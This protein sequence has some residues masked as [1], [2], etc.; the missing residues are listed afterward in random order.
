MRDIPKAYNPSD[1]EG[2]WYKYWEER[3]YFKPRE[4]GEPFSIVIP[5]PN[6]TGLL[7]IGHALNNTLQDIIVRYK[8]MQGYSVLWI[9]GTDH[10]GIATQNV[11]ERELLKEGIRKE[12]L[13]REKF[14]EKVWEWKEKLGGRIIEQL[15]R[16]GASCDWSKLRF[17]M[18]EGLSYAVREVFFRL[19]K[20]NLI[21][22]GDYIINWCPKCYTALSDLEVDYKEEAGKLYYVKYPIEGEDDYIIIATTRPETMLGDT[23][24]CVNPKDERYKKYIGKT[25]ILPLVGRRLPII[26]DEV[27]SMDFGTGA[28]KVTPSH[29]PVDFELGKKHNLDFI[30]IMD[31]YAVMNDNAA[32]YRGLTREE[33]REKIVKDLEEKGYLIKVEDYVHSVGHCY[34]CGT[35]IEPMVSTQWFVRTKPLSKP[36]IIA[37]RDKKTRFIPSQWEK[38]YF[39]WMENIKDWCISR[40]IWWGH[41]IPVWYKD[42]VLDVSKR[43][44]DVVDDLGI[45]ELIGRDDVI[46]EFEMLDVSDG[47]MIR[48]GREDMDR[49]L[50]EG[51]YRVYLVSSSYELMK[52]YEEIGFLQESDTLDTWFSSG[53]WP[54]S[55]MGWPHKTPLLEKYYPT[56]LLVTGFDIIFFWV[57]RMMMLG[58]RFMNDVPFRDVYIHALILDEKGQKMSK[59]RGNVIDPIVMMDKYGTDALRFTLAILT[60]QGRNI[61][62]SESHIEGYRNF[63]NK[64]W[65]SARFVLMNVGENYSYVPITSIKDRLSYIDKWILHNL[66]NTIDKVS[67]SL[68]NYLFNEASF[69]I[70]DFVWH[71]FCDWYIELS[72]SDLAK[73]ERYNIVM[74]VL[75]YVLRVVLRL[76]H[77]FTPYVTEEIWHL[78]SDIT[79]R[80]EGDIIVASWPQKEVDISDVKAI[81][82]VEKMKEVIYAIRSIRG[83]MNIKPNLRVKAILRT[84]DKDFMEFLSKNME[85]VNS[86]AR[87]EELMIV[88]DYEKGSQT[89]YYPL[90]FGDIFLPLYGLIDIER[91]KERLKKQIEKLKKDIARSEKKLSN[92]D[93]LENAPNDVV[94]QE[95]SRYEDMKLKLEKLYRNLEAL[96]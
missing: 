27:V 6:V 84:D 39:D 19:Y 42:V 38:V 35:T 20:D 64:L 55:T 15:K 61:K 71:L 49:I 47:M 40:Q 88:E 67:S 51:K 79:M 95:K 70:Y 96:E 11:V 83:D 3:E 52:R 7:H 17:T 18:D 65:N 77:P 73:E 12:D 23:A 48:V 85:Y 16:L 4:D 30:S 92:K 14:V 69:S 33:A 5:P 59:T 74:N 28:L 58:L 66:N 53:L 25:A 50:N 45:G 87:L 78:I 86:L 60:V 44:S 36:A 37:V 32:E 63:I 68:D 43:L 82:F 75:L 29:D 90:S 62:L 56:S 9:P 81:D 22:R 93:F 41:R 2:K 80:D 34:R 26:A 21:Y 72:K 24:V 8:R 94:E 46:I 76:L 13:G 1:V 91:E 57:A 89:A 54:F 31:L 10:A